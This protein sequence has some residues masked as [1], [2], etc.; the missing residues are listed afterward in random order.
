[1][2]NRRWN[3][4]CAFDEINNLVWVMG[5]A[6]ENGD[7]LDLIEYYNVAQNQWYVVLA[8]SFVWF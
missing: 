8:L 3:F 4:A 2:T 7:Q 1:M 5:G 6:N